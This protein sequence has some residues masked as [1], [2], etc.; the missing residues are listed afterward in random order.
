MTALFSGNSI[1]SNRLFWLPS[2]HN[3][4]L[5]PVSPCYFCCA[6]YECPKIFFLLTSGLFSI[7]FCLH[8][9]YIID[10]NI[11]LLPLL[12]FESLLPHN[13]RKFC[14]TLLSQ[15]LKFS[16]IHTHVSP[17]VVLVTFY[18][19]I[20]ICIYVRIYIYMLRYIF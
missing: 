11:T 17:R 16:G 9:S 8:F 3:V 15:S 10:F 20:Y 4:S 7:I 5:P 6:P 2:W 1:C 18:L 19:Y 14:L 13:T 12:P